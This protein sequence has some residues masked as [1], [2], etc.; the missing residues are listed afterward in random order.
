M[1]ATDSIAGFGKGVGGINAEY[2]YSWWA[3]I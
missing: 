2:G 1:T 3:G